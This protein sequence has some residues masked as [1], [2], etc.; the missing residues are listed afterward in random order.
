M[1]AERAQRF[2]ANRMANQLRQRDPALLAR[3]AEIVVIRQAWIDDPDD[4]PAVQAARPLDVLNRAVESRAD[5]ATAPLSRLGLSAVRMLTDF[6]VGEDRGDGGQATLCFT[7][8]EGFTQ[9]TALEGDRRGRQLLEDHY[10]DAGRIVR[11]RNGTTVKH[12]G[13]GQLLRFAD[14]VD[15]V[16]AA[17][18][19][20]AAPPA[21]LK[22][23]AG[24]H[25][26]PLLVERGDVFGHA[27]NVAA[28]VAEVADGGQ[29]LISADV[30]EAVGELSG[31]EFGRLRRQRFKGVAERVAV[32]E[33]RRPPP[34][35]GGGIRR[36]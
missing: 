33:V 10:R 17:L 21:P 25:R 29:V 7:D 14:S 18:D 19:I 16:R 30:Y 20:V 28:R 32:C 3:L 1:A 31:L 24:L 5:R 34:Q 2:G 35:V 4:G 9:Y 8:L 36:W 12:L 22:V 23:R 15:A 26:G 13:D 27:V 11:T 6:G